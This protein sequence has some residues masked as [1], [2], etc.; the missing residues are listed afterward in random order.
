MNDILLTRKD[1][2]NA[3]RVKSY[4]FI[5][6]LEKCGKLH[7]I[8]LSTRIIRYKKDDVEALLGINISGMQTTDYTIEAWS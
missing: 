4:G 7:P 5:D 2:M 6:R 1:V 3:L 8:R